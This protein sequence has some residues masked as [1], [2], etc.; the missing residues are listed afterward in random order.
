MEILK[1]DLSGYQ[2][3]DFERPPV[4]VKFQYF[5]PQGLPPLGTDRVLSLCEMITEAQETNNPFY[6]SRKMNDQC[7]GKIILGM[8]EMESFAQSGQIGERLKVFQEARTNYILY[9]HVPRIEK[10]VVNYVAFAP[11]EKLTFEPDLLIISANLAQTEILM[12]AMCYSTGE[13]IRS[14]ATPV[15]GCAWVFVYPFKTGKV[16]YLIPEMVHGMHGRELFP[17]N[18]ALISI[19]YHWIS[20][21]S[22]NLNE[23]DLQL[24]SHRSKEA[25][26]EEFGEIIKDLSE[27]AKNP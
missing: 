10:D 1:T 20:T 25:Y 14:T 18:Y 9:Q 27:L 7:V 21:I 6:F 11:M 2:R 19:P 4:G 17:R 23:M 8:A 26:L 13:L 12:R 15:M 16:N 3:L 5:K 24:T 22:H